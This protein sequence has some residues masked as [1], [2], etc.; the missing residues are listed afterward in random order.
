VGIGSELH[1]DDAAGIRVVE[2]LARARSVRRSRLLLCLIGGNAPENVTSPLRAFDPA[3]VLFV[4]AAALGAAA[5]TV[6]L[7]AP[8]EIGGVSFSTHTLPLPVILAYIGGAC[9]A[10][11]YV[12][13]IQPASMSVGEELSPPVQRAVLDVAAAVRAA[14]P[15]VGRRPA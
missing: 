14:I 9:A 5:G 4:D 12:L 6:R 7:V 15:R 8:E 2:R 1:G 3:L 13:A 11:S 10:Q